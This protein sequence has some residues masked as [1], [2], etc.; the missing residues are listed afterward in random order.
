VAA[1]AV[2]AGGPF[3][4]GGPLTTLRAVGSLFPEPIHVV[5]PA[6]SPISA[7]EDLR[8]K[9]VD[10]GPPGSGTQHSAVAVL[11]AHGLRVQDLGEA[12]EAGLEDATRRLA[13]GQLDAFFITIAAPARSLQKLAA[14]PG[15]RLVALRSPSINRLVAENPGLVAM[16]LPPNTYPAQG[17]PIATVATPALLV[18]T[19]DAPD[20]EVERIVGFL[21]GK[22]DLAA[23]GSAEGVKVSKDN[24][25]R[26][27]TIPVHPGASRFFGRK[28][29]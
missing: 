12:R 2:A 7:V 26:G 15:M 28:R 10:I 20:V 16:T 14:G 23:S 25:L 17:E 11:A 4:R 8:G 5:V 18:T 29:S 9:R 13:A 1:E 19:T 21:F 22:A 24:G 27:I 6:A 3:A